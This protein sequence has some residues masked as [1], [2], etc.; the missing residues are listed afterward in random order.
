MEYSF[1]E[2]WGD[3]QALEDQFLK[4]GSLASLRTPPCPRHQAPLGPKTPYNSVSGTESSSAH[5]ETDVRSSAGHPVQAVGSNPC[6]FP[7]G[8]QTAASFP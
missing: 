5:Q 8:S 2:T 1:L 3:K 4:P 7:Q 6:S